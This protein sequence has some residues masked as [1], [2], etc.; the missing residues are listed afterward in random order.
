MDILINDS[1]VIEAGNVIVSTDDSIEFKIENLNF[2]FSF[3]NRDGNDSTLDIK[4]KKKKM[5]QII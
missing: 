5:E 1:T 3:E 2:V 4:A